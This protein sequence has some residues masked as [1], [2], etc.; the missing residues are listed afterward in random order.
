MS[1]IGTFFVPDYDGSQATGFI[2]TIASNASTSAIVVGKYRL[3]KIVFIGAASTANNIGLRFTT[4][5]SDGTGHAA[6]VP[7][8]ASPLLINNQENIYEFDGSIDSIRFASLSTDGAPATVNY[9]ILP[10]SRS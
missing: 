3:I 4:G 6:P 2:G 5:I 8:S 10:L 1:T 9:C 7:T